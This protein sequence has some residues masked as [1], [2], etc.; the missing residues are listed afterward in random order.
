VLFVDDVPYTLSGVRISST[1]IRGRKEPHG[2]NWVVDKTNWPIWTIHKAD[3][4]ADCSPANM[5]CSVNW[6]KVRIVE[7]PETV[8]GDHN[9]LAKWAQEKEKADG[10]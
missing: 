7:V 10:Q 5:V 6:R 1:H 9:V 3:A 4:H 2:F 8:L